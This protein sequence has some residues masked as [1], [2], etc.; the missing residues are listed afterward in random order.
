ML[1][2]NSFSEVTSITTLTAS[3]FLFYTLIDFFALF[4]VS[5]TPREY[6]IV[7]VYLNPWCTDREHV[8]L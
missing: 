5:S 1:R 7:D 2:I 4:I 6:Y 3:Y 8:G